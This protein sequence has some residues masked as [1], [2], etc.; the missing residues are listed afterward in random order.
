LSLLLLSLM[1]QEVG[2]MLFRMVNGGIWEGERRKKE[3]EK[4]KKVR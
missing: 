4:K 3:D 2:G 1:G